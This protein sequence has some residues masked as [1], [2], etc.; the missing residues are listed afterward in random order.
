M[1][2]ERSVP[3]ARS[4][5][6]VNRLVWSA[7]ALVALA[8]IAVL[9]WGQR[10]RHEWEVMSVTAPGKARVAFVR[11]SDC[12]SAPCQT[13]WIGESRDNA[14]RVASLEPGSERCTEIAWNADGTR[15]GFLVNGYQLRIHN[16]ETLSPAGQIRLLEPDG[17][18][19]ARIARGVTFS[20]NGRAVTFDDCPRTSSGCRSGLAAVPRP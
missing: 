10:S 13:L 8:A 12:A 2:A 20:E 9:V 18:P 19:P 14:T 7:L 11:G 3:A 6:P 15:V 5:R 17:T 4:P 1:P 16:A